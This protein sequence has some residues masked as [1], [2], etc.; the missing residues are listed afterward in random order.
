MKVSEHISL[1]E[2]VR[3]NTAQRLGI[4]N[5]PDNETLITMQITA[6]HVFEPMRNHFG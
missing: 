3:S 5:M 2:A 4:H 1:K 6:E